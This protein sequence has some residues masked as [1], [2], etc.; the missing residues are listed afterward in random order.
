[1]IDWSE[2]QPLR[3]PTKKEKARYQRW[4][5]YL[6]DS[7]LSDTEIFKRAAQYAEQGREPYD[8]YQ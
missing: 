6:K 3:K 5:T 4:V 7:R 8:P 2:Q 1:M